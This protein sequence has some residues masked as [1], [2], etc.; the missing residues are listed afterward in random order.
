EIKA[1]VR[2]EPREPAPRRTP[3]RQNSFSYMVSFSG[4]AAVAGAQSFSEQSAG[5]VG[6]TP[7][8]ADWAFPRRARNADDEKALSP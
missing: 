4:S 3:S 1:L 5:R 6:I 8:V 2:A 7:L